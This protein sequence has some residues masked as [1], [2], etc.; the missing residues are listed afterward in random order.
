M[1]E[2]PPPMRPSDRPIPAERT[3]PRT[4]SG[5]I[6]AFAARRART[7]PEGPLLLDLDGEVGRQPQAEP[8]DPAG[9]ALALDAAGHAA[10]D[11]ERHVLG[12]RRRRGELGHV[13]IQ[14][15]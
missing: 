13:A 9:P 6:D 10:P 8:R 2:P 7:R 11:P 12:G 1:I 5:V 15:A 4:K 14:V 3:R